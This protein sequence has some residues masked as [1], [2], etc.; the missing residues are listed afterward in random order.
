M[1]ICP[2]CGLPLTKQDKAMKCEKG[3]SFDIAAAGYCNLLTGSKPGD[4]IGDSKEMVAARRQFLD[5]GAYESLRQALC[6][7]V[8]DNAPAEAVSLLDAGC[9]EGY[10][11]GA[12]ARAIADSGRAATIIGADISKSATAYAAKRDKLTRYITANSYRLPVSSGS[13]DIILSLFAPC[14]AE[15]FKRILKTDGRVI[16][17]VPGTEHLWELKEAIYD[18]PYAN[19]EDKHSLEGFKLIQREKLSY[20]ARIEG[21]ANV[22]ALFS[23]T[24]YIHRTG[25]ESMERLRAIENIELTLSFVL[26]CFEREAGGIK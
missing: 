8:L 4:Y 18:E 20:K 25:R 12:V 14:P 17:A 10:Y 11:T 26:L 15:E 13:A 7:M 22:Q 2:N 24:P 9:G 23:M 19:D 1:L 16:M 3:H 6:T 5:S 21:S